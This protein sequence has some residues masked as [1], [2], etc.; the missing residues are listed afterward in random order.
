[1]VERYGNDTGNWT[2]GSMSGSE[3]KHPIWSTVPE[4]K[5]YINRWVVVPGNHNTVRISEFG[6]GT[7]LES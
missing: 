7:G 3:Y 4:L 6:M 1:M 2:F 5:P